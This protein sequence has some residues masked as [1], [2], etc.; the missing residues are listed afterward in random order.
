MNKLNTTERAKRDKE[1]EKAL[2]D[3]EA[4]TY[5]EWILRTKGIWWNKVESNAILSALKLVRDDVVLDAGCGT[6]R[7][8][9]LVAPLVRRVFGID[10]S[11][12]SIQ[13]LKDKADVKGITNI[14]ATVGDITELQLESASVD[15]VMSVGVIQHIP[16]HSERLKTIRDFYRVLKNGGRL[17][18]DVY[19]WGGAIRDHK[20][21][22]WGGALYRYAFTEDELVSLLSEAGFVQIRVR[23][24]FNYP[25]LRKLGTWT[26]WIDQ[27]ISNMP[28]SASRGIYLCVSAR[29]L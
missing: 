19:R 5:D 3:R 29:K 1:V 6:G 14:I 20:E 26:R 9:L 17:V 4:A 8:T 2:R 10:H 18:F 22:Y 13:I 23:G 12:T 24:I 16:S 21:G 11:A 28:G 15:K 25:R 7:F 27:A